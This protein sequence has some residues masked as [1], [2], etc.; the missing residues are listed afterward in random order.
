MPRPAL[1]VGSSSEG[2]RIAEAAQVLLDDVCE[3]ELWTQGVFGLT[4][5][6]LESLVMAL[7]RFDFALLVLTAD[8]LTI[9]RGMEKAAARDNVLFELGLFIGSLGRDRTFMLYDRTNPPSLPSDLAGIAAAT[10]APHSTGNF[11]AALGAPCR[12]IRNGIERLGI[13]KDRGLR[14]LEQATVTVEGVS[15]TMQSLVRLLAR[16]RKVE[17]DVIAT[18][19]GS[20][21]DSEKLQQMKRDLADLERTLDE[22]QISS[23]ADGHD[24]PG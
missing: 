2:L 8:D 5:G 1:F 14:D 13:K 19:F 3:V 17:L 9:A 16:S 4:Q 20:L 18:Q 11:E 10:F 21:I 12:K 7:P 6:T 22:K 23:P 15:T 24:T